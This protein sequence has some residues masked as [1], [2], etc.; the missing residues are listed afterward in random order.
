MWCKT[1]VAK[2]KEDISWVENLHDVV[3]YNKSDTAVPENL[4]IIQ[5]NNEGREA[6]TYLHHIIHNYE[7]S[8]GH[9]LFVQGWP[10]DHCHTI[11]DSIPEEDFTPLCQHLTEHFECPENHP[12]VARD[13]L[14]TWQALFDCLPPEI[15]TFG[16]G[17]IFKV[18][19]DRIRTRSKA[20]YQAAL[21]LSV[22]LP[23]GP[24][25]IERL[26]PAILGASVP[27]RL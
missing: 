4:T 10:F 6:H 22:N 25:A 2:Y 9:T 3:V 21:E 15:I 24:W 14:T 18:S 27:A 5:L 1:V 11:D 13:L 23:E 20:F 26:W 7:T 16:A 17:A 12:S 19:A 8:S